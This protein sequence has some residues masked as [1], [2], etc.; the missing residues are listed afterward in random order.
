MR[1]TLRLLTALV[2]LSCVLGAC[3]KEM[4][5]ANTAVTIMELSFHNDS[6]DKHHDWSLID[7]RQL[8]V[9]ANVKG[10]RRIELLSGNPYTDKNVEIMA[11]RTVTENSTVVMRCSMPKIAETLY[12]A[13]VDS[14]EHYYVVAADTLQYNVDFSDLN[15]V[16]SGTLMS[17]GE[18]EV[19]YCFCASYPSFSR[20]ISSSM[21]FSAVPQTSD[22]R[23]NFCAAPAARSAAAL[24]T[25]RSWICFR[26]A[27]PPESVASV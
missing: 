14:A 3:K 24:M 6:V 2:L 27:S 17:I 22:A 21:P 25:I 16:N 11:T 15:T 7:D 13:A 20:S 8:K 1:Q 5:D 10:V 12:V 26:S 4:F 23:W 19:Y 18:Q 9:T